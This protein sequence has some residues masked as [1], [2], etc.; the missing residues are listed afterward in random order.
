MGEAG[1]WPAAVKLV[2]EWFPPKE[3]AL[4]SGIF[5]SGAAVGAIVAPPLVVWAQL[6]WGWQAAFIMVGLLGYLWLIAWSL[7]YRTP[8]DLQREVQ[9]RPAPP[10]TLLRTRFGAWFTFSRIF[11]EPVWYFYVFWFAKYLSSVHQFTMADIG[12]IAW[13]PFLAADLGN[14]AGGAFTQLLVWWRLPLPIARK[15][16]VALFVF[17]MTAAIPVVFTGSAAWA[18]AFISLAAFGYAGSSA[19]T[20]AFPADVFPRNMVGSVY[21]LASMGAGFGGMIFSWLFGRMID[22]WGYKPVFIICGI[23]PLMSVIIILFLL[24]PLRPDRRFQLY[25]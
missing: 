17:L 23:M 1:N 6:K 11:I 2:S 4:A 19:N 8:A 5:N 18:L 16:A 21:G 25:G 9:A 15:V 20:L 12:K 14:L 10:L 22:Q 7:L 3:R 24:G 13:I